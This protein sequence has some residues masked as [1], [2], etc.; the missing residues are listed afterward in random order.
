VPKIIFINRY[1]FPDNS[2]TSQI[3]S[4]VAF[5]LAST[6]HKIAII[7]SRQLYERPN[8]ELPVIQTVHGVT[9]HRVQTTHFGRTSLLGRTSDYMSF[10]IAA[11]RALESIV[12][13]ND[14]V[15]AK[16]DP[17]LLSSAVVSVVRRR[18]AF[19]VNWLQDLYPEIAIASRIPWMKGYVAHLLLYLRDRSLKAASANVVV[20]RQMAERLAAR[21]IARET[22]HFIPN[23]AS[24][25]QISPIAAADN[26]LRRDWGL[27]D[28][29][30]IGYSGNLGRVHEFETVLNAALRLKDEPRIV[31]LC[32]GGGQMFEELRRA[33]EQKGLQK[34]FVFHPYLERPLLSYSLSAAD[35][36]W[37][38]LR[39]EFEGLVV[40]SKVYGIA[41]AGRPIIAIGAKDGEIAAL[42]RKYRCGFVIEPG[43]V[44]ALTARLVALMA[45]PP[46]CA[47]MGTNARAMLTSQFTQTHAIDRWE[48]LLATIQHRSSGA[49]DEI[50]DV[51][52]DDNLRW[53]HE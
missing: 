10:Y 19:L 45:S 22:I 6:G 20:G 23:F 34:Q 12:A 5:A 25:S 8:T 42:I 26:P 1:F 44:A 15:V 32:I 21:S 48:R 51:G 7:T 11:R 9:I 40:P 38:S 47:A 27:A 17:P 49:G 53:R 29:F 30:V 28:K 52:I 41:A 13:A 43:D 36:H 3:V 35:V 31:F 2:A 50:S 46:S 37:M 33:V 39:P 24:D 18:G 4:D 14:I 16:T